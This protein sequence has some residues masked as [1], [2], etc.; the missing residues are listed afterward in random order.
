MLQI[1][2][3]EINA[4]LKFNE[5]HTGDNIAI[6]Y[7]DCVCE[8]KIESKIVCALRDGGS[9]FV[10]GFNSCGVPSI[11]CL[12]HSLQ[13]VIHDG[14]LAQRDV[15]DLLA[16]GRRIVGHYKHSNVA[17]HLLQRIQAQLELKVCALYQDEP[18]RWNSSYYMLKRLVEQRKAISA[19]NAEA[20]AS[21]DL[22][23]AQWK[24]AE[25]VIKL[26]QP[27]EE[28]TEDISSNS[29]S[30]ALFI[31]IVNSLNK[32]LQVDEEDHGI[33]AMKRKMLLS[34]QSRFASCETEDLYCLSTFLDPRFKDR[35]FSSQSRMVSSK[36]MLIS[37]CENYLES[38]QSEA[39][40]SSLDSAAKR[41]RQDD[42]AS[43]LW[44]QVDEMVKVHDAEPDNDYTISQK[45]VNAYLSEANA[46]RH[47][48]PLVYWNEKQAS[49]PLLATL[50][51][52]YLAPPC[53]TVP[54]ERLFST[55]GNIVTDKRTK[56][57]AEK[58]EMLLL[59]NKNMFLKND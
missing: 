1:S 42:S 37:T 59:L 23:A 35:V 13:C 32:L 28:A 49:W 14:V 48:N 43:V 7:S 8:W 44:A 6:V 4:C 10:A 25:K 33:M 36:E 38:N 40:P 53:T 27:F 52:K 50:A 26:L 21:F 5:R 12:A 51:R 31:P 2:L 47:S 45:M 34:M 54:S 22:S 18:T 3:P 46:P 9:N 16:A 11:T 57:D 41:R 58:V 24:L 17:F 56:L 15:Q 39:N 30:I 29:S 19:A 55:A 20:G